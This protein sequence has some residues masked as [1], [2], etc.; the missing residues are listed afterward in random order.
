MKSTGTSST[1]FRIWLAT[2]IPALAAAVQ[3]IVTNGTPTHQAV[4]GLG[5]GAVALFATL[6][7]LLHD[8]SLNAATLKAGA[9]DISEALPSLRLDLSKSVSFIEN[10][11]P[12]FKTL[13]SGVDGRIAALETK[14]AASV[15]ELPAIEAMVRSVLAELLQPKP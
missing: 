3:A 6:G 10:D 13:I 2:F 8:G 14:V 7:K 4:F 1:S 11:V 15:P 9:S 5:G 12:A